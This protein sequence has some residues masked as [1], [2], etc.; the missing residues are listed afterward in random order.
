VYDFAKD[1][2]VATGV[3]ERPTIDVARRQ[4]WFALAFD[5]LIRIPK[6]GQYTFYVAAK[7]GGRLL[8]DGEEQFESDGRKDEPLRQQA[9]LALCQGCHQFQFKF[10]KCTDKTALTLEWSGPGIPRGPLPKEVLFHSDDGG[11]RSQAL[12]R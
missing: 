11:S 7:D 2:P 1:V 10:F 6:S 12:Q 4:D 3:V 5:G 9:T 8:I